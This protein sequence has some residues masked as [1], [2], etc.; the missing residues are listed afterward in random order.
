METKKNQISKFSLSCWN[1]A[2][3]SAERAGK[4]AEWL[5]KRSE[6]IFVLTEAKRSEGCI[7]LER[8]FQA[9][10]YNVVFPKPEGKEFG[11]IIVSKHQLTP[12]NFS[13][14]V[15]YLQARVASVKLNLPSGELEII[16]VY[17]PSRDSSP[18]KTEKKKHFLKSLTSA[19]ETTPRFSKRIFCGDLNVLE[20][21]HIP[22]YPIFEE[23][24]YDFYRNLTKYQL[25]DAFRH[26]YPSIQ[27]YSWVGR[28]G[29]GYRYDHCFVSENLLSSV[30]KCYYLHGPREKEIKLSDH[31]AL[32]TELDL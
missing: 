30:K 16:G 12:S 21:S 19:L 13:T 17:V 10:G 26:L 7:F 32:I 28:T 24:E 27:E 6:D 22:H 9:Y 23:W 3:P 25:K 4:Q 2:N 20:P 5:R 11:V 14:F 8:Y 31:S 18:E 15:N 1:I 29:D